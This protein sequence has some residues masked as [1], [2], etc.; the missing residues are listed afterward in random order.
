MTVEPEIIATLPPLHPGEVLREEFIEPL[1]LSAGKV[2][3]ACGVPR[4]RVERIVR[5]ELGISGDTAIRLARFFKTSREFWLN[6]Q[7][8]YELEMAEK[9]AGFEIAAITPYE[10]REGVSA[11]EED[12]SE[13]AASDNVREVVPI[14]VME[15]GVWTNNLVFP[16]TLL[17]M[18]ATDTFAI[19]ATSGCFTWKQATG[20]AKPLA[21]GGTPAANPHINICRYTQFDLAHDNPQPQVVNG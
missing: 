4:T 8:R 5:E 20:P 17:V 15:A 10:P 3:K 14:I 1:G 21:Q 18:N 19:G 6:L 13:P 12:D 7:A 9:N 2:A 11:I 16:G